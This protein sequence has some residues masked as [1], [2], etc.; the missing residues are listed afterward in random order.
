MP[1]IRSLLQNDKLKS[2]LQ[3]CE[4]IFFKDVDLLF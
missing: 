4:I 3:I 2:I 1:E